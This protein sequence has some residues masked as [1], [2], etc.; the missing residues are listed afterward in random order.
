MKFFYLLILNFFFVYNLKSQSEQP[1]VKWEQEV[2]DYGKKEYEIVFIAT[3]PNSWNIVS[4]KSDSTIE[5][6]NPLKIVFKE[7]P[8][9]IIDKTSTNSNFTFLEE[10]KVLDSN[11]G[12][13]IL[14]FYSEKLSIIQS[15][16]AKKKKQIV[17]CKIYYTLTN[18]ENFVA[19]SE[20]FQFEL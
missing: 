17:K 6:A 7:N 14:K 2:R 1:T 5:N 18:N 15:I 13:K 19:K 16:K 9:I 10:G 20:E 12:G 11:N 3:I 8:E 4:Q